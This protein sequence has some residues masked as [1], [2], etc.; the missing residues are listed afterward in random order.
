[1]F[2]FTLFWTIVVL[3]FCCGLY[4]LIQASNACIQFYM[5]A[6]FFGYC[7]FLNLIKLFRTDKMLPIKWPI[8]QMSRTEWN[9][10]SMKLCYV[11]ADTT[12]T[13]MPIYIALF[14]FY[15]IYKTPVLQLKNQ[16]KNLCH[17]V[18]WPNCKLSLHRLL[19]ENVTH[20][21]GWDC[22]KID[23]D[24]PEADKETL[25]C[26]CCCFFWSFI[27]AMTNRLLNWYISC[28]R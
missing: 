10:V 19:H 5:D 21:T 15:L 2:F 18:V 1:M 27:F 28:E 9:R 25:S 13:K 14:R 23:G 20:I 3:P 4:L 12:T 16:K 17:V 6:F 22:V 11:H 26:C 24:K 7:L 8:A